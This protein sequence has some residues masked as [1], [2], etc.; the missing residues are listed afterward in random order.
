MERIWV[1][2][3]VAVGYAAPPK[4]RPEENEKLPW[5]VDYTNGR[6]AD[7]TVSPVGTCYFRRWLDANVWRATVLG[8]AASGNAA[9]NAMTMAEG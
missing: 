2:K 6:R 5:A 1:A 9:V 4:H 3:I 8:Q 7:G